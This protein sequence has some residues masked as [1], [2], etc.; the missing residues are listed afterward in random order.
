MRIVH[1]SMTEWEWVPAQDR[2]ILL[3]GND[4]SGVPTS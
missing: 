1:A 3:R 4:S 2:W